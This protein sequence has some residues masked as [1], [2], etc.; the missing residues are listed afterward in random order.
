MNSVRIES[1]EPVA[2]TLCQV[3]HLRCTLGAAEFQAAVAH[4]FATLSPTAQRALA[5]GISLQ[6]A[7]RTLAA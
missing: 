3:A 6:S 4:L 5:V 7:S 1:N 2:E